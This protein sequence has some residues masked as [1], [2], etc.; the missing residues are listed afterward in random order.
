MVWGM[1]WPPTP[2]SLCHPW[3]A[4]L[5]LLHWLCW[6][7][8][9]GADNCSGCRNMWRTMDFPP[10]GLNFFHIERFLFCTESLRSFE[11]HSEE[12]PPTCMKTTPARQDIGPQF[13]RKPGIFAPAVKNVTALLQSLPQP[14][15]CKSVKRLTITMQSL[16]IQIK[17]RWKIKK[18]TWKYRKGEK[19]R[20]LYSHH[21]FIFANLEL[22][23]KT[24]SWGEKL[25]RSHVFPESEQKL[26]ETEGGGNTPYLDRRKN[27]YK[28]VENLLNAA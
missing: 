23:T 26:S 9:C 5:L 8:H 21:F 18:N 25:L 6:K 24:T 13:V 28:N 11:Q 16:Y 27:S 4:F 20:N 17:T 1:L 14:L 7:I 10:L 15:L 3:H 2:T 12:V 19:K 22:L